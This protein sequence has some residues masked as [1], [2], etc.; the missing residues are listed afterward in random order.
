MFV[1]QKYIQTWAVNHFLIQFDPF[2]LLYII[3]RLAVFLAF[4]LATQNKTNAPG[5]TKDQRPGSVLLRSHT[6]R[7]DKRFHR[8]DV[9]GSAAHGFTQCKTSFE[10][11]PSEPTLGY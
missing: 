1:A 7:T 3:S 2:Q 5:M 11:I 8:M 4:I 6:G 9:V 10:P